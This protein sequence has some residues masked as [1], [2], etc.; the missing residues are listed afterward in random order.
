MSFIIDG[1]SIIGLSHIKKNMV[2]QDSFAKLNDKKVAV[3]A[4]SDGHGSSPHYRSDIG[5]KFACDIATKVVFNFLKDL[6]SLNISKLYNKDNINIL[7]KQLKERIVLQW[8]YEVTNHYLKNNIIFLKKEK[9]EITFSVDNK[10]KKLSIKEYKKLIKN[11]Q[12]LYGA[13]LC[14][15]GVS[16]YGFLSLSIGDTDVRVKVNKTV[17]N[18]INDTYEY[19]GEQTNSL[20][21]EDALKYISGSFIQEQ[22][23]MIV[24]STDGILKSFSSNAEDN[25]SSLGDNIRESINE[26]ENI[27]EA[28]EQFLSRTANDGSCDDSTIVFYAK[29]KEKRK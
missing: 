25:L 2:N 10:V 27:S 23:E 8:K 9:S 22:P 20:C 13:T 24:I 1:K 4:A 29:K 18:P 17:I 16:N 3:I 5:S 12:L 6:D 7:L 14:V 21:Q 11:P 19:E 28:L 15:C 26:K